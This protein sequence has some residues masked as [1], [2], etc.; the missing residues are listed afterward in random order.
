MKNK[1]MVLTLIVLAIVFSMLTA[2][3]PSIARIEAETNEIAFSPINIDSTDVSLAYSEKQEPETS[4]TITKIGSM[5][6]PFEHPER[7]VALD[8]EGEPQSPLAHSMETEE[9]VYVQ[10]GGAWKMGFVKDCMYFRN[11]PE[12]V[13]SWG[14]LKEN[15]WGFLVPEGQT[16]LPGLEAYVVVS[17]IWPEDM[18]GQSWSIVINEREYHP[19]I[20]LLL[21]LNKPC[22]QCN[23]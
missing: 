2:M 19:E 3:A 22:S 7:R 5:D 16:T 13:L 18:G 10:V 21:S 14:W 6:Y 17:A 4:I 15:C 20:H 11:V 8:N 1:K 12:H 23:P 9:P